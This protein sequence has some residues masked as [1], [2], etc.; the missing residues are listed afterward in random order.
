MPRPAIGSTLRD[1]AGILLAFITKITTARR[2]YRVL[3]IVA[4]VIGPVISTPLAEALA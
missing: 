2:R 4:V 1:E 3:I